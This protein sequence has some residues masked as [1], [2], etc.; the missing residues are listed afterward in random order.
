MPSLFP[1]RLFLTFSAGRVPLVS[2]GSNGLE[3]AKGPEKGPFCF[4]DFFFCKALL[5]K[6]VRRCLTLRQS[7][8]KGRCVPVGRVQ[9]LVSAPA[10]VDAGHVPLAH[11][12]RA[13]RRDRCVPVGR[14]QRLVSASASVNAGHVPP[15]HGIRVGRREN[16]KL[17]CPLAGYPFTI[18]SPHMA[19]A[20]FTRS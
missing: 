4:P 2:L 11:G 7:F 3:K 14:V 8:E 5:W 19:L 1:E 13:G 17:L 9:R 10:S 18:T 15:T 6:V 16:Q 20:A 12:I